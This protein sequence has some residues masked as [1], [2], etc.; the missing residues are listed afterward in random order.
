MSEQVN[1]RQG[2]GADLDAGGWQRVRH[3]HAPMWTTSGGL[4]NAGILARVRSDL[5]PS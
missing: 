3:E 1:E 4:E 2:L 5:D